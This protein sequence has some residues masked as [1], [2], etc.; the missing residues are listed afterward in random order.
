MFKINLN[1]YL[2]I[3]IIILLIELMYFANL[4]HQ[5]HDIEETAF[6][7]VVIAVTLVVGSTAVISNSKK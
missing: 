3:W 5:V 4:I 2:G 6:I 1:R 7:I